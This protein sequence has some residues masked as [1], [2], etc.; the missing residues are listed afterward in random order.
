MPD[1][2]TT[3]D[4][5]TPRRD[6]RRRSKKSGGDR[7][8]QRS[9]FQRLA[10][11][12]LRVFSRLVGVLLFGLRVEGRQNAPETGGALVCSNHQSFFDPVLVGLAF[13]RRLNYMARKSLFRVPV[14]KQLIVFLNAIPLD[15]SGA[16][17]EGIKETLKRLRRDELVLIFPE[18]TRTRDGEL[19]ALKPGF[20]VLARRGKAPLVP[21]AIDGAYQAWPRSSKWPRLSKVR[22]RI[23]QPIEVELIKQLSDEQLIAEL[24]RRLHECFEQIRIS[25]SS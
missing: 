3:V 10:Y 25:G 13:D 16:G 22:V 24:D 20:C 5:E 23:G 8:S 21:V 2:E 6:E 1:P 4:T 19:N 9:W 11:S 17:I 7:A 14:L 18:G 15:R 12:A